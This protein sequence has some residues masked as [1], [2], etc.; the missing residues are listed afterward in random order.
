MTCHLDICLCFLFQLHTS[1]KIGHCKAYSSLTRV[2]CHL[3]FLLSF[4]VP[5]RY[6]CATNS[7]ASWY[8]GD[9]IVPSSNIDA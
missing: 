1:A 6:V 9:C 8:P 5:P 4:N 7:V 2:S 3:I